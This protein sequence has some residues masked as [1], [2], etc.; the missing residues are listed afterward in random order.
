[1]TQD[2]T[3]KPST[4]AAQALGWI[5]ET[6]HAVVPP[7]HT[8]TTFIRDADNQYRN[9]LCYGRD[10]NPSYDQ[11]EALLNTLE[12]GQGCLLFASGMAA[13]TAVFQSLKPG[14]HVIA[15]KVMYWSLRNW[16]MNFATHW[17]LEAE[18]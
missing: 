12:G 2:Q 3:L 1:M 5:D 4:L 6:T 13:A 16:L 7:I 9:G 17:G 15:P 11:A 18:F 8:S 10:D 14:D